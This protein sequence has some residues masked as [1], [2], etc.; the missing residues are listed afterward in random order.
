MDE[1]EEH[2]GLLISDV[3][4]EKTV[5]LSNLHVTTSVRPPAENLEAIKLIL[6][7]FTVWSRRWRVGPDIWFPHSR[8]FY[9]MK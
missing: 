2:V 5:S 7:L 9:S 8:P 4:I 3:G 6:G 1:T